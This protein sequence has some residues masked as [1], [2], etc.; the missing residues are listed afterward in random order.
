VIRFEK[1]EN[2][3]SPKIFDSY[4]YAALNYAYSLFRRDQHYRLCRVL[5]SVKINNLKLEQC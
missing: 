3:A 4:G 5:K 2:I 1:N